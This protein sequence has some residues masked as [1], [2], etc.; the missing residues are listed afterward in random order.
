VYARRRAL[1]LVSLATLLGLSTWFSTNA[2]ASALESEKS[3]TSTELAWLVI[4]VQFGFVFGTVAISVL[5]L[6]DRFSS[7]RLFAVCAFAA[8]LTNL[9]TLPLDSTWS[10]FLARFA[11]GALLGGVYPPA[12]KVL[13]GWYRVG[14]G[15]ALGTMVGALTLGSGSPHLLG[16]VFVDT[17]QAV[18]LGSS[19]LA[20]TGGVVMWLFAT[21]GPYETGRAPFNP[22]YLLRLFTDRPL[23]L[24]LGGYLGHMW[25]LYAMWAWIGVFLADVLADGEVNGLSAAAAYAVFAVGAVASGYAGSVAEKRGRVYVTVVAMGISGMCALFIGFIPVSLA[26]LVV[27][28]ALIWGASVIADS[29]QFSTAVSEL[30][31]PEYRGTMLTFQTGLGFALTVGSI[32]L[33]PIVRDAAGWGPAFAILAIGPALGIISMLLL[34]RLPEAVRMANG[35]R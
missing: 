25:E 27:F 19:A 22:R 15:F 34:R 31:E 3:L 5:N 18:I 9:L 35:N 12:M 33:I 24:A 20:A 6:A 26:P 13:S 4:A 32:W 29:A 16:S 2:I 23:S 10:L 21:D 11:T 1:A 8:A 30:A 17:W 7:R 28:V 14:R